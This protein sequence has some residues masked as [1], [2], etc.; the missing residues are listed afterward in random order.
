MIYR[1]PFNGDYP[2]TQ[3][4]GE[5]I[6]GVTANG[7]P[8]TGIDYACPAGTPIL[9]SANGVVSAAGWDLTGYGFR[10]ILLHPDGN[11]TLYAHLDSISVDL[12]EKVIQGQE[13]GLSGRTGNV[14]PP[15]ERGNHLHFEARRKWNDYTTHFNPIDLPMMTV[16]DS[17]GQQ[18]GK[19]ELLKG[20][21]AF[22]NGDV[23]KVQN[24]L[25]VKAFFD[26][27]FSYDR[28]TSY[29]QGTSFYFTGD[30]AV[31]KKNGLTYVRVVPTQF[32]VW[33]AV[34]DGETQLLDK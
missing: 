15:D 17:I 5:L 34:N 29:P 10:V 21:E 19:T 28:V 32:S 6:T 25:G 2:I 3:K 11:G 24:S 12:N 14:Y 31:N 16:D 8:H 33:I 4:Y 9:A 18:F 30:S 13:I 7:K 26:Q 23:L 20:A 27:A 22:G 1:Q